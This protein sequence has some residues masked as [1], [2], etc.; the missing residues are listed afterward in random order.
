MICFL[1]INKKETWPVPFLFGTLI[2]LSKIKS[3]LATSAQ[4]PLNLDALG[5]AFWMRFN[6]GSF[7]EQL[8]QVV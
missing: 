1:Y 7:Q 2:D 5:M 3:E 4:I 8:F 6:I